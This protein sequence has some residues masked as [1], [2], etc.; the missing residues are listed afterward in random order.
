MLPIYDYMNHICRSNMVET[1]FCWYNDEATDLID[2]HLLG[3]DLTASSLTIYTL[4]GDSCQSHSSWSCKMADISKSMKE[5][6]EEL[7]SHDVQEIKFLLKD[8][9]SSKLQ[10]Y[11]VVEFEEY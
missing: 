7:Q 6:E 8:A 10:S 11:I 1:L 4:F 3:C 2:P 5:M 9:V